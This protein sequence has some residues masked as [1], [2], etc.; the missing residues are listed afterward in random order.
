MKTMVKLVI[1][2]LVIFLFN[3][4][5]AQKAQKAEEYFYSGQFNEAIQEYK[6][7]G[8]NNAVALF[9]IGVSYYMQSK[10]QESISYME[11]AIKICEEGKPCFLRADTAFYWL[12]RA[13]LGKGDY[14]K[15]VDIL[16]RVAEIAEENPKPPIDSPSWRRFYSTLVP[17][18]SNALF[19]LGDAYYLR[20]EYQRAVK[21]LNES[22]K[23]D[24]NFKDAFFL[25]ALSYGKLSEYIKAIEVA[26]KAIELDPKNPNYYSILGQIYQEQKK[27]KEAEDNLKKAIELDPKL[28]DRYLKLAFLYDEKGEYDNVINTLK[29]ALDIN[30][31]DMRANYFLLVTYMNIGNF[32]K[33]IEVAN[34]VIKTNTDA[35]FLAQRSLCYREIGDLEQAIKDA[36]AAYSLNLNLDKTKISLGA[37]YIDKGKYD[38]AIKIL[39]SANKDDN[40]VKLLL[41]TGYAKAAKFNEAINIYND[42]PES[43]LMTKS[44]LINNVINDFYVS[45]KPYK[46]FILQQVKALETKG[47]YKEAIKEYANLLKIADETEAKEIRAYVAELMMK[48]PHLFALSEEAR[49]SVIKAEA[50]TQEGKFEKA[51]EEY[52]NALKTSP[53]FPALY[54]A[55]ALNYGGL[56]DYKRAIKNMKIY[57]E[58]LPDAPDLREAKDQIYRWEFMMEKGE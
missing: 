6:K 35:Q 38:E 23:L 52:K 5:K 26:K 37:V 45:L 31:S 19:W 39:S 17:K 22:I 10:Y 49:K 33:A 44:V 13:Y 25:L 46:I 29:K 16:E 55:L 34:N 41:A 43:Y 4:V 47:Q 56:K 15:A 40:F 50:Y 42:I 27:Y 53:F 36:E 28:I 1:S 32:N 11:K 9:M 21:T 57:L 14:E 24:P 51:I 54:K 48:Y 18:K 30:P 8:E 20:G 12:G 58:L 3:H 2:V 7:F